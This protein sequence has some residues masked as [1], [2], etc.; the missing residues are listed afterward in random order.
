M[1]IIQRKFHIFAHRE[2]K[3]LGVRRGARVSTIGERV[4]NKSIKLSSM[5]YI[6]L[7]SIRRL[8]TERS[9]ARRREAWVEAKRI[10]RYGSLLPPIY[11]PCKPPARVYRIIR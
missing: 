5:L 3:E 6:D 10:A 8:T 11:T 9:E 4:G 2:L 1:C 7:N